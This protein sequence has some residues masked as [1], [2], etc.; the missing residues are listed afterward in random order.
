LAN[1]YLGEIRMVGFNFAPQGWA[2]C[3]GQVLSISQNTALFALLGTTYGGNGINTFQLPDLRGR[4]AV[5]LGQGPGLSNYVQG[6]V[7]GTEAVTLTTPQLPVHAHSVLTSK[8]EQTTNRPDG[9]YPTVGGIY[10]ATQDGNAPMA[11]SGSAGGNQ[12][13]SNIQPLLVM[14][15]VIALEGI[16]PARN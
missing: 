16:F 15:F 8:D 6:E 1:P 13:H 10:A 5:H 14:N 3:N 12:P 4:V 2:M 9:A 11:P 7:T